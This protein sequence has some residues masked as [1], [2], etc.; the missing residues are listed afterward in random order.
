M[1]L[2]PNQKITIHKTN[3]VD[4]RQQDY[5]SPK[6]YRSR[7]E[8]NPIKTTCWTQTRGNGTRKKKGDGETEH[9]NTKDL[10]NLF[11]LYVPLF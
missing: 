2:S 4:H 5:Q 1:P 8:I 7:T 9:Y 10:A 6:M 3:I 11:N